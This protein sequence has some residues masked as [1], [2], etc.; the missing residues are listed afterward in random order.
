MF[1]GFLVWCGTWDEVQFVVRLIGFEFN[2]AITKMHHT[3]SM[4]GHSGLD[5]DGYGQTTITQAG[6]GSSTL[7][8]SSEANNCSYF[9]GQTNNGSAEGW[10]VFY[11]NG[12]NPMKQMEGEDHWGWRM[13]VVLFVRS[14]SFTVPSIMVFHF[15]ILPRIRKMQSLSWR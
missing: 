2:C 14:S 15:H 13:E 8:P 5:T 6:D 9:N 10:P 1:I 11:T 4:Y 12:L 3:P 7:I